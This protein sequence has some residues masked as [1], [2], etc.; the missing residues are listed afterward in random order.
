MS[1]I[2][3]GDI[4]QTFKKIAMPKFDIYKDYLLI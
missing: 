2:E 3:Y 1:N 4:K